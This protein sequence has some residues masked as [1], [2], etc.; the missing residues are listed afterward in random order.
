[1]LPS[2]PRRRRSGAKRLVAALALTLLAHV[3]MLGV[4]LLTS[5][6]P[7]PPPR[8]P[9]QPVAMRTISSEEWEKNRSASAPS[10][11]PPRE[12]KPQSKLPKGQNVAVAPGNEEKPPEDT[13]YLAERDNK[14]DKQTRAREQTANYKNAMPQR[15]TTTPPPE[16]GNSDREQ[17]SQQARLGLPKANPEAKSAGEAKLQIPKVERRT[18]V[19][20]KQDPSDAPGPGLAVENR[21]QSRELKGNAE[22]FAMNRGGEDAE[23]SASSAG[24]AQQSRLRLL[25]S[26]ALMDQITG[27]AAN[28]HLKEEEGE[29]TY[30]NTREFKFAGFF[31]RIKQSVG[32]QWNPDRK[33]AVRDPTGNIYS[34]KDRYTLLSVTLDSDGRVAEIS[35]AK[36]SGVDFLDLEAVQAFE[37][38]QPFP[39]PPPGLLT[40]DAMVRFQFGFMVEL[41]SSPRMQIFRRSN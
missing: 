14:V 16:T 32:S 22:R 33:L 13:Q 41:G 5:G 6:G 23:P 21:K 37:R 18:A 9:P 3:V 35:V 39:N 28:D 38:A 17:A 19:A 7:R 24:Q 8:K 26:S 12:P 40:D 30:L 29:G 27:A 4:I 36:S 34:G 1:M 2:P 31:N 20:L 15:T 11:R 25:P 10:E